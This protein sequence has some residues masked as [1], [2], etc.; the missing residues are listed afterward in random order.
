M[1]WVPN[2]SGGKL[3]QDGPMALWIAEGRARVILNGADKPATT[4]VRNRFLSR[5]G[6]ERRAVFTPGY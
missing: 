4:H 3:R 1:I 6:L 5:R 2:K